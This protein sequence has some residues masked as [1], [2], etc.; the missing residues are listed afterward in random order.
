MSAKDSGPAFPCGEK[1]RTTDLAG[2]TTTHSKGPL[3]P[4]VSMRDYFA[5]HASE[6]DVLAQAEVIRELMTQ[7]GDL[8]ILADGWRVKAR[9]MHADEMLKERGQ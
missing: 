8:G 5:V 1:Y 4:G 2:N 3:H 6:A 7:R 9:Y